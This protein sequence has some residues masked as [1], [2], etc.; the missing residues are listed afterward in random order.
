MTKNTQ[1][2]VSV[3]VILMVA[4]GAFYGGMLYKGSQTPAKPATAFGSRTGT[5]FA[6]GAN[7]VIGNVVAMDSQTLTVKSSDGSS[8]VILYSPTTE[9]RKF[10]SGSISDV[11]VGSTVMVN[12]TTN[13]DGSITASS[14]Q[15]RPGMPAPAS[16]SGQ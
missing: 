9:V 4:A 8:K 3:I 12:G 10:T 7:F 15:I 1:Y 5:R 16:A 13:T 6:T 14:I 2:V 11:A